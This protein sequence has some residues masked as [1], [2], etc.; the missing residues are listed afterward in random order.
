MLDAASVALE[1]GKLPLCVFTAKS[2]LIFLF[3][4]FWLNAA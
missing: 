2:L 1:E 4:K 3:S